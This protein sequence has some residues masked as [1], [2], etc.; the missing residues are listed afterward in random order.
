[1]AAAGAH[2]LFRAIAHC[3]V[4]FSS[5][6]AWPVLAQAR[7]QAREAQMQ[8]CDSP[9]TWQVLLYLQANMWG[10]Q[11]LSRSHSLG[12]PGEMMTTADK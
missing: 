10:D 12:W 3:L 11:V 1:M 7:C 4:E 9:P 8:D 5:T 2:A 6:A